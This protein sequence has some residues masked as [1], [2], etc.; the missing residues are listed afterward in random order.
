MAGSSS[1]T[2]MRAADMLIP[3][4]WGERPASAGWWDPS[5][6]HGLLPVPPRRTA[7][8]QGPRET[9]GKERWH[10]QETVPQRGVSLDGGLLLRDGDPPLGRLDAERLADGRVEHLAG[11]TL[12]P[13][14]LLRYV[15][16]A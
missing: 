14:H 10:G 16:V 2:T 7:G 12:R 11:L 4:L 13:P 3:P 9:F 15:R 8:L 5:L 6:W 1:T